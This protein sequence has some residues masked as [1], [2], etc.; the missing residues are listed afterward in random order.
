MKLAY[1]LHI[2]S[3]LSP[4]AEDDMT[5]NNIVNMSLIKGLDIIAVTDHNSA[6]NVKSVMQAAKGKDII[7][8]PGIE[9]NTRED[10]HVLCY[11]DSLENALKFDEWLYEKLIVIPFDK[12][13]FGN[14]LI[15]DQNDEVIG[16][17]EK[18]LHQGAD[19]GLDEIIKA[20]DQMGGIAVPA[21]IN[22][23][24]N[25]ILNI[26]GF[27][28]ENKLITAV[29]LSKFLKM[30]INDLSNYH[31]LYSSDAHSL[32]LILERDSFIDLEEKNSKNLIKYLKNEKNKKSI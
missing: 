2:H 29:E 30:P 22:R 1:D 16:F 18:F 11:F 3:A 8:V 15:I 28:P 31:M 19:A 12:N 26:L 27:I 13:K 17:E 7:I 23:D 20:A 9:V 5:P 4:C 24:A 32:G 21:H 14:Q 6:K 25:S 10:I